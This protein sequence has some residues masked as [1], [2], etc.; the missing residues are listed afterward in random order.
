MAALIELLFY[1]ENRRQPFVD[2]SRI[3]NISHNKYEKMAGA[4]AQFKQT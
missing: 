3:I 4:N 2:N 1:V